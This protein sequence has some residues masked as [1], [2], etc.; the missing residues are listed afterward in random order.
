M[1][2]NNGVS[3]RSFLKGAAGAGLSAA[4]LGM[5]AGCSS[6]DRRRSRDIRGVRQ[7]FRIIG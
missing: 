2:K 6:D 4:A 5:L 1:E 7:L 3:R